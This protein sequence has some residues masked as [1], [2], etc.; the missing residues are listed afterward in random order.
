MR[1]LATSPLAPSP[2]A[3]AQRSVVPTLGLTTEQ[4]AQSL[5]L[6]RRTLEGWRV[7]GGGPAFV[8]LTRG[9]VRYRLEDLRTWLEE[10][11]VQ[12]TAQA[13]AMA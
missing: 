12:N 11:T 1:E 5:A 4:A 9:V 2:D 3:K 13:T 8:K 7:R 10:R 6:S